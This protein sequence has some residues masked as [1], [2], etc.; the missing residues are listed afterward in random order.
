M[1]NKKIEQQILEINQ[2]LDFITEQMQIQQEKNR[3][4]QDLKADLNIIA[5]D[6]FET[7]VVEL[8][9]VAPYF[10]STDMIHL[11]KKFLRNIRS[12]NQM[13]DYVEGAYDLFRDVKPLSKDIF[14]ELMEKLHELDQKGLFQFTGELVK[15]FDTILTEFSVDDVKMLRENA[16]SILLTVKSMTQPDM[17]SSMNNALGF[18]K[19]MDI[20][21]DKDVS[22]FELM[23]KARDPEVKK[24][25]YFM[26]E[27][28]KNM[29]QTENSTQLTPN[30]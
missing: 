18:F 11:M 30:K 6:I 15:I 22:L 7:A 29:A 1:D 26:L 16:V 14:N 8:E 28:V 4:F 24:G 3:E 17:L 9:D 27:F 13:F 20:E 25:M 2:K 19:K 10:D 12:I 21:V 5:K 23:K